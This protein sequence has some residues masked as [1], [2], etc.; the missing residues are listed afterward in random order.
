MQ[1]SNFSDFLTAARAQPEAQRLLF[2][3]AVAELP[4]THTPGQARRF[5]EGRGGALSPVMC[6]DK[7][8]DELADFTM[9]ADESRA[10]GQPWDMVL[11]AALAGEQQASGI[12]RGLKMMI[13][14]V[15]RGAIERFLAFDPNGHAVRF[16]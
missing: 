13:D 5:E 15:H 16:A 14:A 7:G 2:V 9:L 12:D 11:V 1:L 10:T 8:L 3:F 6:V 4:Q